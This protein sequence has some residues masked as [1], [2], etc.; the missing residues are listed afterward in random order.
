LWILRSNQKAKFESVL[1]FVEHFEV[2]EQAAIEEG[3]NWGCY[4]GIKGE[5]S[6]HN[7]GDG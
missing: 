2:V 1:M 3:R 6:H 4:C 7:R 5:W